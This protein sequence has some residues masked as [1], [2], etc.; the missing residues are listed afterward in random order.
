MLQASST[1]SHGIA[2]FQSQQ[3]IVPFSQERSFHGCTEQVVAQKLA[4]ELSQALE[5]VRRM[6]GDHATRRS[7]MPDYPNDMISFTLP[8]INRPG[9]FAR[10]INVFLDFNVH[11][12]ARIV[13]HFRHGI[14]SDYSELQVTGVRVSLPAQIADSL[15]LQR[16]FLTFLDFAKNRQ[17]EVLVGEVNDMGDFAWL[18]AQPGLLFQGDALSTHLSGDFLR[19]WWTQQPDWQTFS[20]G[21]ARVRNDWNVHFGQLTTV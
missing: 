10:V 3:K 15:S 21:A 7:T 13:P 17:L 4:A 2:F 5:L 20:F 12:R 14:R 16:R 8:W 9:E 1:L 6:H 11:F 18:R 19:T